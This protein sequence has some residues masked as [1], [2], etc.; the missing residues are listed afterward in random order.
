[1]LSL[2]CASA[3]CFFGTLAHAQNEVTAGM[4]PAGTPIVNQAQASYQTQGFTERITSNRVSLSVSPVEALTLTQPNARRVAPGSPVALPHRLVNTGNIAT[5]FSVSL[6]AATGDFAPT[7][8][9]IVRDVNDNGQ[10]DLGEPSISP[11][12]I[13]SLTPG[14]S[15][16]FVVLATVPADARVESAAS[17]PLTASAGDGAATA[18]NTDTITVSSGA[19]ISVRKSASPSSATRGQLVTWSLVANSTG[20]SAPDPIDVVVDGAARSSVILRDSVPANTSFDS[21]VG[22]PDARA[23]VLYY[24][25]GDALHTYSSTPRTPVDAL[26]WGLSSFDV[27]TTLRASFAARINPNAS[28]PINNTAMMY[29]RGQNAGSGKNFDFSTPSNPVEVGVPLAPPTLSF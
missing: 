1:L 12:D 7:S 5:N 3:V 25:A 14:E 2:L 27:G 19:A 24:R 22:T 6:G 15:A 26:A 11:G 9:C 13:I 29:W 10:A 28:T 8:L 18:S 16:D 21:V 20:A 4:P 23:I 17:L